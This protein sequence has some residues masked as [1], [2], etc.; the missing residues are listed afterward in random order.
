MKM[1]YIHVQS[2]WGTELK[3]R[4]ITVQEQNNKLVVLFPGKNYPCE[5]PLLYYAGS[6]ALQHHY[7]LLKLEYGY[8]ATRTH[9]DIHDL[10]HVI[11]ESYES[12]EKI[13]N[14]YKQVFFI[15]K[16]LGTIVAGEVH[17][18]LRSSIVHVF[19]TPLSETIP[20]INDSNGV[21]IYGGQDPSF[22]KEHAAQIESG[23]KIMEIPRADHGLEAGNVEENLNNLKVVTDTYQKVLTDSLK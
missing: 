21:V 18:R 5:L 13:I 9:L 16:S 20:Y 8:Q 17:R 7:D 1:N 11:D 3:Q 10:S 14:N 12:I 4:H 23:I 22:T 15:S 2:F 6:T 19:L